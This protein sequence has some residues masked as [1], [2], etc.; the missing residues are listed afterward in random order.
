MRWSRFGLLLLAMIMSA[1]ALIAAL[2]TA[3]PTWSLRDRATWRRGLLLVG[4]A[5]AVVVFGAIA[6]EVREHHVEPYDRSIELAIHALDSPFADGLMR[7]LTTVGSTPVVLPVAIAVIVWAW[8][9]RD[10]R[11]A[12]VLAM[13]TAGTELLNMVLKHAF[14]RTRPDLFTEIATL[15]S[16]SFPSGHAMG[17]AAI[18]GVAAIVAV[19]LH[20]RLHTPLLVATPLIVLGIGLSRIFLGVHWPTDVAAGFAAGALIV[21]FAILA[22]E[23]NAASAIQPERAIED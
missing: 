6:S 16:Y 1:G 23:K 7:I 18:Y 22:L 12:Q 19:R 14:E 9:R 4:G 11:A 8:A 17:A 15:H 10:R 2:R 5:T 13:T 3:R 21:V 20:R